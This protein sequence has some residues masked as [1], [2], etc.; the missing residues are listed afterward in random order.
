MSVTL[1]IGAGAGAGLVA[2]L[3]VIAF[4]PHHHAEIR[5]LKPSV[6]KPVFVAETAPPTAAPATSVVVAKAVAAAP[7]PAPA[8]PVAAPGPVASAMPVALK[9]PDGA[10]AASSPPTAGAAGGE[11][12]RL[13]AQG[14]VAL[15]NGDL[16][17]ARLWLQR[18]AD[19]GDA[20]AWMALGAAYDPRTLARL[21]VV[22]APGDIARARDY[23][24]H[25]AAAG[26]A[27]ATERIAALDAKAN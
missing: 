5:A 3:L 4:W 26:V 22:G 21:G 17:G 1:K 20:R 15:A 10:K 19:A 24:N 16:A 12:A 9:P 8:A 18:A 23:Y 27:G 13:C 14:L 2:G 7:A 25:A 11:A 6:E